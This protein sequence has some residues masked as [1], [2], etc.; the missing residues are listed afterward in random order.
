MRAFGLAL[1]VETLMSDDDR[2]LEL[3]D[4]TDQFGNDTHAAPLIKIDKE[5]QT[6]KQK[7][8]DPKDATNTVNSSW[9]NLGN[10]TLAILFVACILFVLYASY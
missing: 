3:F 7:L 4:T 1:I 6:F 5:K 2:Q 8:I 10:H 9:A